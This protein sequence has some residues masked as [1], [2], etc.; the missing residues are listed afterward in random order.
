MTTLVPLTYGCDKTKG[1]VRDAG[2][3]GDA[4]R[5]DVLARPEAGPVTDA[6]KDSAGA[7]SP[8]VASDA[9][10][11]AGKDGSQP[12]DFGCIPSFVVN[13]LMDVIYAGYDGVDVVDLNKDGKLDLVVRDEASGSAFLGKGDGSFA[14]GILANTD[15]L[16]DLR[17]VLAVGDIDGD[18]NVDILPHKLVFTGHASD[19]VDTVSVLP[20]KGDGTFGALTPLVD[21][22]AQGSGDP[23]P[24]A[25]VI[26]DFNGDGI[27]DLAITLQTGLTSRGLVQ[28]LLGTGG[29]R[30]QDPT[31]Y[32]THAY[33]NVVVALDL[34]RDKKTDLVVGNRE[35]KTISVFVNQGDGNFAEAVNYAM[36]LSCAPASMVA[37]DLNR[38]GDLD[39]VVSNSVFLSQGDGTLAAPIEASTGLSVA[40][41]DFN[42]DGLDDLAFPV[43][44]DLTL[45]IHLNRGDG[46]FAELP[47]ITLPDRP[48]TIGAGDFNGDGHPDLAITYG[49]HKK[50][51]TVLSHCP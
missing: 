1:T 22:A 13:P 33:P 29:G 40:V 9:G 10:K 41:A 11:S 37:I 46:T 45:R 8:E 14:E 36:L 24:T 2:P 34:N 48:N 30:F 23:A 51:G 32:S 42:G 38:D 21:Y 3:G 19:V 5:A 27:N 16:M 4:S 17:G 49:E 31:S 50:M 43:E 12:V 6:S 28:V 47:S 15:T 39:L 18:G 20:G 35:S 44:S 7:R 25:V 26:A